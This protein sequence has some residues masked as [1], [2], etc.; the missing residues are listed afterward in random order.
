[1]I[2]QLNQKL[3]SM[4]GRSKLTHAALLARDQDA[5]G[6]PKTDPGIEHVIREC[7]NW[8]GRAQDHSRSQ[9]GG[10]AR[11]FSLIDGWGSSYPE[12]T[13]YIV[14]TLLSYAKSSVG[15]DSAEIARTRARRMLAW[16]ITIQLPCG[17]FQGG[18]IGEKPIVPVT[19]N[20]GQILIGLAAGV[21]EFGNE[22]RESLI[23]NANWLTNTQELDGSWRRNRS[24][25]DS[26]GAKVYDAHVA[27]GLIE[28]DRVNP[29]PKYRAAAL[30]N[31]YW[32]LHS[33]RP[34]GWFDNCCL[35]DRTQPLTH[36]IGYVLRGFVE[37]YRASGDRTLLVAA[38]RTA[39]GLLTALDEDGFLPGRLDEYWHGTVQWSCLTGSAQI[40]ICW[41]LLYQCTGEI[42]FRDAGFRTNCFLRRTIAIDGPIGIRGGVKGCFPIDSEYGTYQYLNWACKFCVDAQLMEFAIRQTEDGE[43][44]A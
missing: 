23:R 14:P 35:S 22:F 3:S 39:D 12:T 8:I 34:N 25:F 15:M 6:L 9:D 21:S 2:R 31:I 38:Q 26:P 33:Q 27:W 36:A 1:M 11:H 28:A 29:N 32:A 30:A 41:L 43:R 5:K 4:F 16:L 37:G 44:C 24:P 18:T 7:V 40:A 13:G 17:G 10:V 20:S 19:F 42:R